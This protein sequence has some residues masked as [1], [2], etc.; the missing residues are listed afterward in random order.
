ML[1]PVQE[2]RIVVY[3]AV[4]VR[5]EDIGEILLASG[6]S[7]VKNLYGGIF[8]WKNQ[9]RIVID[10]LKKETENVHAYSKYWG[11]LLTRANKVY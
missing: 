1:I 11:R 8:E 5:S 4:G 3:C 7:E 2:K 10:S 6:Y 9:G